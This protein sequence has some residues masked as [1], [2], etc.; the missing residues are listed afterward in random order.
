MC[1]YPIHYI[2][3]NKDINIR[4]KSSS[5]GIFTA[6]AEYTFMNSG[7]VY[8]A[9]FIS[10]ECFVKHIRITSLNELDFVRKSKYVW[11]DISEVDRQIIQ[12]INNQKKNIICWYPMPSNVHKK[13]VWRI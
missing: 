6:L 13:E 4:K 3:A 1:N 2:A 11:S 5:G 9:A 8:A 10:E 7:A 12:D